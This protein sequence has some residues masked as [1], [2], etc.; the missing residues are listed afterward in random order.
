[1]WHDV[2][3][4]YLHFLNFKHKN[5]KRERKQ[6]LKLKTLWIL[7]LSCNFELSIILSSKWRLKQALILMITLKMVKNLLR[8]FF[9]TRRN[10]WYCYMQRRT[11]SGQIFHI[12]NTQALVWFQFT[13]IYIIH[14]CHISELSDTTIMLFHE[15]R[16]STSYLCG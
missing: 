10:F 11:V 3:N 8:S 7:T 12:G 2:L 13:K 15:L 9:W 14:M 16:H 6:N 5:K 4:R 1:M